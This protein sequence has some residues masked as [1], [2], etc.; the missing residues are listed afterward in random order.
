MHRMGIG[1]TQRGPRREPAVHRTGASEW[2]HIRTAALVLAMDFTSCEIGCAPLFSKAL[3][4]GDKE[5]M[6]LE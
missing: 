4:T 1:R 3:V 2:G 5:K 6:V